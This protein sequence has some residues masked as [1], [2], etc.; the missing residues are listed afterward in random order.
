MQQIILDYLKEKKM[1]NLETNSIAINKLLVN[2]EEV[3]LTGNK[4]GLIMLA[5]YILD[6]A[7]SKI[8][9]YHIHLD[10]E[11]FLDESNKELVIELEKKS[12]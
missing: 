1:I 8:D 2:G 3:I 12:D 9:G 7:L 10:K 6:V 5:D 11:N 4:L